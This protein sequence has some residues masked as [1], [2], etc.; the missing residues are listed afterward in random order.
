MQDTWGHL[1]PEPRSKHEGVITLTV[2]DRGDVSILAD[3][4]P[5]LS[6]SPQR[7]EVVNLLLNYDFS[8]WEVGVYEVSCSLWFFKDCN[9]MYL[10][11]N[12]VGKIINKKVKTMWLSKQ[13]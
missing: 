1:Y 4:F 9:E 12:P 7:F 8:G 3:H 10:S 2:S 6:C 13:S 5:S 11:S